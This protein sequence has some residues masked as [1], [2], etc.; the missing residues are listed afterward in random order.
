MPT[1]YTDI[2]SKGISFEEFVMSCARA[3]GACIT[4]RDDPM[5]KPIPDK[6]E[7]SDYH[8][9]ALAQERRNLSKLNGMTEQQAGSAAKRE[10]EVEQN[11]IAES[12]AKNKDLMDK[13]NDMLRQVNAWIPPTPE[14]SELKKFMA[15]QITKSIDFDDMSK[16]YNEHPPKLLTGKEWL[17]IRKADTLRSIDY[18]T[19]EYAKEVETCEGRSTWVRALRDS[20]LCDKFGTDECGKCPKRFR[21]FTVVN[22]K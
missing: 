3:F 1:G 2:I 5:D 13:Y 6:F 14:H 12:T 18:H 17:A 9:K 10:Y 7:P 15:D 22:Y 8:K 20:L 19:K 21:C 4:M 11:R 16:Y